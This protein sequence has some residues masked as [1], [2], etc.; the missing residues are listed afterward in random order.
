MKGQWAKAVHAC[1][2]LVAYLI[3]RGSRDIENRFM[4]VN[5]VLHV[6]IRSW[7]LVLS[8][9]E[10]EKLRRRLIHPQQREIG[11]YYW[12]LAGGE[13]KGTELE[14]VGNATEVLCVE[15]SPGEG[16]FIRLRRRD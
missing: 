5:G 11:E 9:E 13:H 7:D 15:S 14:V 12:G 2:E 16:T 8:Q 6:E 3:R 10:L 1:G 4:F